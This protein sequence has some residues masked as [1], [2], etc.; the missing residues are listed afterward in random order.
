MAHESAFGAPSS[1]AGRGRMSSADPNGTI[2]YATACMVMRMSNAR[3]RAR[4]DLRR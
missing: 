2:S 4:Q 1:R 3:T